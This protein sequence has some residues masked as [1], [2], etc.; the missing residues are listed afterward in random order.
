MASTGS[1]KEYIDVNGVKRSFYLYTPRNLSKQPSL[2]I[3]LHGGGGSGLAV[4]AKTTNRKFDR[5][6]EIY[7][8]L[9]I[10]PNA[11]GGHWN[12]G[13]EA[14]NID[15]VGFLRKLITMMKDRFNIGTVYATGISNGGMLAF[16]LACEASDYIDA[17]ATVA[18]SMPE[19][20]YM[21]C[22]PSK[23]VSVLVVHGLE[24]PIVPWDG[25]NV[26]VLGRFHGRVVSV[27]ETVRFWVDFNKCFLENKGIIRE[28]DNNILVKEYTCRTGAKVVLYGLEGCG[29]TWPGGT[30]VFPKRLVG[31]SCEWF[32]AADVIWRFFSSLLR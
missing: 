1:Q 7:G 17:I 26:I 29:H 22:N 13:R 16:R 23:P 19:N 18:A 14:S 27:E 31:P 8:F 5:L 21:V 12:D 30:M 11:V 15:D 28:S 24:D 9:V 3:V 10:Y 2:L 4:E 25:G 32:D 6:A 20:L